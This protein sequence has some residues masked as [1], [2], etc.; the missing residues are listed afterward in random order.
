MFDRRKLA[1][2]WDHTHQEKPTSEQPNVEVVAFADCLRRQ[3][4]PGAPVLD[5]GCGRG[6]NVFCLSQ[7]GFVVYACDLSPVAISVVKARAQRIDA[8]ASFQIADLAYMP[9]PGNFFA[10]VVCVHVLPYHYKAGIARVVRELRRVLRPGGWL[11]FDLLGCDDAEYGCGQELEQHTFLDPDGVPIHSSSRQEVDE[12]L[13]GFAVERASRFELGSLART[14]VGW[15][16]WARK[17]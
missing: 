5:A 8:T 9:Y 4:S 16:V 2:A 15:V 17:R 6:R 7:A 13:D 14:R 11:Y 1:Q 12:L 3:L 10:A